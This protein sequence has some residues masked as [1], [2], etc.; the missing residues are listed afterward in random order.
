MTKTNYPE[1]AMTDATKSEID[2]LD[3]YYLESRLCTATTAATI[4]GWPPSRVYKDVK[5]G[6][7]PGAIRVDG[8]WIFDKEELYD[9]ILVNQC[10]FKKEVIMEAEVHRQSLYLGGY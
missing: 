10:K 4:L 3:I 6:A 8:T 5:M 7:I 9:F 2:K 1:S